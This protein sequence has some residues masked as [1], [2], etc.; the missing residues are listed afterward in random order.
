[1]HDLAVIALKAN[2]QIILWTDSVAKQ[3][4]IREEILPFN[5][6]KFVIKNFKELDQG[7]LQHFNQ[8][9]N[10]KI[11]DGTKLLAYTTKLAGENFATLADFI[12]IEAVRQQSGLYMDVDNLVC[13]KY[14]QLLVTFCKVYNA[15]LLKLNSLRRA[16]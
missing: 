7:T 15:T 9:Q 16:G 12:R 11:T 6:K 2:W 8:K 1:M 10:N 14:H 4:E 3:E 13:N 5:S